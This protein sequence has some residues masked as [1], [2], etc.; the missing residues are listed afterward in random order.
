MLDKL[1]NQVFQSGTLQKGVE[2]MMTPAMEQLDRTLNYHGIRTEEYRLS[3]SERRSIPIE[4]AWFIIRRIEHTAGDSVLR[5]LEYEHTS[6]T[7][8]GQFAYLGDVIP[9]NLCK[10]FRL[11]N[12]NSNAIVVTISYG[13]GVAPRQGTFQV[14]D[15]IA[16]VTP[17]LIA[18]TSIT[19]TVNSALIKEN[20][21][22]KLY[23]AT[24]LR[25]LTKKDVISE[26]ELRAMV[27]AI[28][29]E[30]G[31]ADGKYDGNLV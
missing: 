1:M 31:T 9:E 30:D 2:G 8:R 21:E 7:P 10:G 18:S 11:I 24:L 6:G 27:S 4:C 15:K 19:D 16:A 12:P 14:E 29:L 5:R 26:Q 28:D 23:L 25:L 22:L 17:T 20:A 3:G 13:S